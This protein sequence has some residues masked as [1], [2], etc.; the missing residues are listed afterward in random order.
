ME[1][2]TFASFNHSVQIRTSSEKPVL[3]LPFTPKMEI[4]KLPEACDKS[5]DS[6]DNL[7]CL[8]LKQLGK[9]SFANSVANRRNDKIRTNAKLV[10]C[11]ICCKTFKNKGNLAKHMMIHTKEKPFEC[12]FCGKSFNQKGSKM[13]HEKIHSGA[14]PFKCE[15]CCKTFTRKHNLKDHEKTHFKSEKSHECQTCGKTF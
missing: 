9:Y 8:D 2:V 3:R 1:L 12:N 15:I 4:I 6:K 5:L 10:D 13:I 7:F 14:K 11:E